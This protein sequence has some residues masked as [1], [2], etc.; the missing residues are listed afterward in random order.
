MRV[1]AATRR[2]LL[3]GALDVADF[4][5]L[6]DECLD[7]DVRRETVE[8]KAAQLV[9][10]V[11]AQ[12]DDYDS[13]ARYVSQ[14][15]ATLRLN[16]FADRFIIRPDETLGAFIDDDEAGKEKAAAASTIG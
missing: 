6:A 13:L 12:L 15:P 14:Q 7:R 2:V 10:G 3:G 5:R 11:S 16:A 1:H 4:N 9:S 8:E